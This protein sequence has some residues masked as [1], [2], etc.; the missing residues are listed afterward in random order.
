MGDPIHM[1]KAF[2]TLI[3]A[4]G[5]G[6]GSLN[7]YTVDEVRVYV[8]DGAQPWEDLPDVLWK[9]QR[10]YKDWPAGF[11]QVELW[12]YP[13][14]WGLD[15][16]GDDVS[17]ICYY[18]PADHTIHIRPIGDSTYEG[19]L[20]HELAHHWTQ[21]EDGKLGHGSK[22]AK[23]NSYIQARVCKHSWAEGGECLPAE[24]E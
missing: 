12:V 10:E 14:G 18:N 21:L 8:E 7:Y 19:C 11:W 3:C 22:W 9:L 16:Y 17:A 6:C 24:T 1:Y 4:L 5:G 20:A 2:L 13:K 23:Y 15:Y